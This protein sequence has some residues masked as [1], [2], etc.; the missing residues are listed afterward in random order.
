MAKETSETNPAGVSK[1][2]IFAAEASR[3]IV[4][5]CSELGQ[6]L[7]DDTDDDLIGHYHPVQMQGSSMRPMRG[8][9]QGLSTPWSSMIA[10]VKLNKS[11]KIS[12]TNPTNKPKQPI[13]QPTNQ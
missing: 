13:K 10:A 12:E 11:K 4:D 1:S 5:T 8:S 9:M 6:A 7:A 3:Y 2:R